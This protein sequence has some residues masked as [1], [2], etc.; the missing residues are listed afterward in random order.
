MVTPQRR[1]TKKRWTPM[2]RHICRSAP[3]YCRVKISRS[4][5]MSRKAAHAHATRN[6]H[7]HT[8]THTHNSQATV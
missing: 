4:P 7:T 1:S 5:V 8:H 2:S 6:T 3:T